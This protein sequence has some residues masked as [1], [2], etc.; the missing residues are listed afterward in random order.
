MAG[1]PLAHP[2]GDQMS[3]SVAQGFSLLFSWLPLMA[4]DCY[5][6][7]IAFFVPGHISVPVT[8]H[9]INQYF[10]NLTAHWSHLESFKTCCC[11]DIES[12]WCA[13]ETSKIRCARGKR[14]LQTPPGTA[15]GLWPWHRDFK[16]F[17]DDS[18]MQPKF[19]KQ[20]SVENY[21]AKVQDTNE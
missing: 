16:N 20:G 21:N 14:Q 2:W 15:A 1:L 8:D 5:L 18:N 9:G 3:D 13:P 10:L 4:W 6:V 11:M 19:G 12:P 17:T 7:L